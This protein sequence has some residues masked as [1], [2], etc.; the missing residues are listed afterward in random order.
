MT[1]FALLALGYVGVCAFLY[2]N[3][4]RLLFFPHLAS[5][6]ELILAGHAEEYE[7]WL[8]AHGECIGWQSRS[9]DATDSALLVCHGNGSQ[10]LAPNYRLLREFPAAGGRFKVYLLE[11]PGYGM[12]PGKPSSRSLTAAVLDAIDCIPSSHERIVLLGQSLGT[13]VVCAA[14]AARSEKVSGMVLVTPY[15][16]LRAGAQFHYP[17][18]P[19]D[20]LL[21]HHF[22][23]DR[24]LAH[25]RGPV[26]FLIAGKDATVPPQL[27]ERLYAGYNGPKRLW[28]SPDAGHNDLGVLL[29]DW[30]G[31]MKWLGTAQLQPALR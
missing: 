10:A 13:G 22:D 16:S 11:Y 3:Q 28:L 7:P 4:D 2:A 20:L 9:G 25:Y 29:A 23:S 19:I 17:W 26:A 18:L 5:E 12:R 21:R 8:N 14:A 1:L 31:I 27:G 15:D 6:A 30:P 24:N